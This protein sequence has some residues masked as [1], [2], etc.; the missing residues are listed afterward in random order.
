VWWPAAILGVVLAGLV[1]WQMTLPRPYFT[2]TDSVGVRSVAAEPQAGQHLCVQGL[3]LPA[4]TGRV[5]LAAFA[6]RP[7]FRAAVSVRTP[8]GVVTSTMSA[9]PG[10]GGL[11]YATA[12]IP[13]RAAQ[14]GT[15]PA[16]VCITP[17][18]GPIGLGGML[19]LQSNQ[20]P[21]LLDGKPWPA[22]VGVWFLPPAG[23]ERS[24]LDSLGSIFSRAALFRPGVVGAWTY[25]VLLFVVLPLLWVLALLTLARA[26]AA[27]PLRV[28]RLTLPAPVVLAIV[29]FVNFGAWAL[30]T[31]AFNAPDEPDHY[32]YAQYFAETGKAPA[33]VPDARVAFS[34]EETL[35]LNA[36]NIY[37]QVSLPDARP[38][39]LAA[40]QSGFER[41]RAATKA[42]GDDGGGVSAAASG[43]Q[44]AYY[45]LLAPAYLA[46][47]GSSTFSKLTLMR[48]A[49]ALLG[50]IVALCAYG[51][52]RELLP[53]H[54]LAA[55]A[56]GLL[57]AFHPMFGFISG[58]INDDVGVNATSAIAIYLLIRALRRGLT[59]PVAL[60][61][62]ISVALNPLMKETGY[63]LYPV[64]VVGLIGVAWNQRERLRAFAWR[65][66]APGWAAL[67]AGFAG[68][69]LVWSLLQPVFYPAV[70]GKPAPGGGI[71][72]TSALTLA[73][74]MPGRFL[75]YLWE[76]FLPR[77]GFMG[78]L[79]PPH[80]PFKQIYVVR[81]WGAF[82]WYE[83]I[84]P[85]WVYNVII[86]AMVAVALGAIVTAV[87][88]RAALRRRV[89][90]VLV[91]VLTPVCV[92]VAV[93][94][95][96][97]DPSG[98]RTVVAEQGRYIF[99]AIT[100]L[101]AIAVSGTFVFGR[102]WY[103][104]L[105]TILVV[106]MIGLSFASQLLTLG[107]FYT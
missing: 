48:L 99:P 23:A 19:G 57:V 7:N 87:R 73:E 40:E 9:S 103:V 10:P 95:A 43:H 75:V 24:L 69:R 22:R 58:A 44:P 98:G 37:S 92:V 104:P 91:L 42:H 89:F 83:W 93:E 49:S 54:L 106:A 71:A 105:A 27:R 8:S 84:F 3:Q 20:Q 35:A 77:L 66:I 82:G 67:V 101:A 38:P 47:G 26:A 1:V 21:A 90:E 46:A 63:E 13:T 34:T 65:A 17:L 74:H 81:G 39:W 76:L 16:T 5:Q 86:L 4:G 33:R 80:W 2:G 107:S 56:A 94:A 12:P 15:V 78:A 85:N 28:G 68:T 41:L 72:A 51:V 88:E 55:I 61:I 36:V 53:R 11:V 29:A 6:H 96:F 79:F 62:G 18:D 31:P 60:G 64:A 25:P 30:I 59:W 52:V 50:A 102:R 32:A 45:A 14:P 70:G 97:F 100:A